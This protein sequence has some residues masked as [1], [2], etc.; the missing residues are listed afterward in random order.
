M[1]KMQIN[2]LLENHQNTPFVTFMFNT[3][4]GLQEAEK[5][6][7]RFKNFVKESKKKFLKKYDVK[8]WDAYEKQMNTILNSKEFFRQP[9]KSVAIIFTD[10]KTYIYRLHIEV[11]NQYYVSDLPYL[12]AVIKNNQFNYHHYLLALNRDSMS[13]YEYEEESLQEL[14]LPEDAPIDIKT[15]L[16]DDELTG[17]N[18]NFSVQSS[19]G[20]TGNSKEGVAYHGV[21]PKDEE[22]RIDWENYFQA[23]DVFLQK[24]LNQELPLYLMTL[25]ENQTLYTKISKLKNLKANPYLAVSPQTYQKNDEL[26][27]VVKTLHEELEQKEV[28]L[29]DKLLDGKFT[30][31]LAEIKTA[32]HDGRLSHFFLATSQ[33]IDGFGED[34]NAEY[35]KRQIL[36]EIAFDVL[37]NSGSVYVLDQK[38]A[39]QEKSL[40]GILRF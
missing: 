3:N 24:F 29:Y 1:D 21:N 32:A 19:G 10:E 7:L 27:K 9:T 37:E 23:V 16:G 14:T 5:D 33:L 40:L 26:K 12:L 38:D 39:P 28:K 22:V 13:L 31:D 35:D 20:G 17:G 11:D 30:E 6:A 34:P 15:A 25:P 18:L 4:V 36:N 2:Q 8:L